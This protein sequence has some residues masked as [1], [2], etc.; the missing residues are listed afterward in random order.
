MLFVDV[1]A[2][3]ATG[4]FLRIGKAAPVP[5]VIGHSPQTQYGSPRPADERS[6]S[7]EALIDINVGVL[8]GLEDF[9]QGGDFALQ[10]DTVL[11]LVNPGYS[12]V[13]EPPV[14]YQV[15]PMSSCQQR[16]QIKR[17]DW[18]AVLQQWNRGVGIPIVVALPEITI[19]RERQ[20]I[21]HSLQEAWQ[22]I[23][24]AD[25][26]GSFVASRKAAELL[27]KLSPSDSKS[28]QRPIT[29][30]GIDDRLYA[31]VQSLFD[32]AGAAQHADGATAGYVP[33]R[34]DAVAL[35]GATAALTQCL[36]ARLKA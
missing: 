3:H 29:D 10:I 4:S 11:L 24:G 20:E 30:R 17:A 13:S 28:L 22:K 26:Q 23:D 15:H 27:R 32:L 1:M 6:A 5:A 35:A 25:Y 21:A 31:V 33:S 12:H 19:G 34:E 18:G 8:E 36:F 14:H 16:L 2:L 7:L 9:R